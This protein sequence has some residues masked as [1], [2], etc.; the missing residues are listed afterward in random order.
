[1]NRTLVTRADR[2]YEQSLGDVRQYLAAHTANFQAALETQDPNTIR[3]A[4]T[5]FAEVLKEIESDSFL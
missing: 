1:E 2:L 5:A 4:R 3:Q